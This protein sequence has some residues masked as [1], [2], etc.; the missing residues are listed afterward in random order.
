MEWAFLFD[1]DGTL[2]ELAPSPSEVVVHDDIPG[3]IA[4]LNALSGGAVALITGRA[5]SDVDNMLTLDEVSLIGQHGYEMRTADGVMQSTVAPQG[6][7]GRIRNELER[8]VA[9]HPGLLLEF[10]GASIALH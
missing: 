7:I 3:L 9:G 2:A 10:K 4:S 1:I 6:D 8:V 5:I